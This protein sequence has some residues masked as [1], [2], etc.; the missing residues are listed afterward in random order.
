M[1]TRLLL[2]F[3]VCVVLHSDISTHLFA[4]ENLTPERHVLL[5]K[6][7]SEQYNTISLKMKATSYQ[8]D[9]DNKTN[10]KV[11][12]TRKIISR[13]TRTRSFSR[14]IETSYPDTIPHPDY[15]PIDIMTFA[16]TP[17]WSKRLSEAPDGRTPRGH[18][19][20][21]RLLEAEQPFYNIYVAMW[22]LYGWSWKEINF[23]ET[24]VTKDEK[25]NYYIMKAKMGESPKGPFV[26]LYIDPAKSRPRITSGK[27]ERWS[28]PPASTNALYKSA[29]RT[30]R[31]WG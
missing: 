21:G 2:L 5:M 27:A 17:K 16:I 24:T 6:A 12:S 7:S 28:R 10:P 23:N 3:I 14:T 31:T 13:W 15:S 20:P 30:A 25:N 9:A 26:Q 29:P 1:N 8:Y 11:K 19:E 18:V 22:D 4:D